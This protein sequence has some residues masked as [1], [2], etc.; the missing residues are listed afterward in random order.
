[1]AEIFKTSSFAPFLLLKLLLTTFL[2]PKDALPCS[3]YVLV[4]TQEKVFKSLLEGSIAKCI[5]GR[6]NST[7]DVTK[8]VTNC[9]HGVGD[10]GCTEGVD[11]HHVI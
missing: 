2:L 5:A 8:P 6:V 1:M 3:A 11:K 10:A 9:P 4:M 7:V